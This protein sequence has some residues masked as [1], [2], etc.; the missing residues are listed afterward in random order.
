MT[1]TR[2]GGLALVLAA[3][4]LLTG[5]DDVPAFSPGVAARVGDDTISTSQVDDVSVAYCQ[6]AEKQLQEDQ[7]LPQHYLRAQVAGSL[8]LRAAADQFAAEHDVTAGPS[9]DQAVRQ[10]EQSLADLSGSQRQAIIDVQGAAT[11]VQAVETAVGATL[12]GSGA[13]ANLAA[14]QK[15]F[16][17]WLDAHDVRIDPLYGVSIDDGASKLTDTGLSFAVSDTATKADADQP[18]TEYAGALPDNQRCG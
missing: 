12:G 1:P 3:A 13:K 6:A 9:Y 7:A 17:D 14:G 15:A 2:L 8:A 11:Y 5:C 4:V 18:D 16:Q 10:A